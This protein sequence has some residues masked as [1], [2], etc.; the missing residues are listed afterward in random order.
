MR[1]ENEHHVVGGAAAGAGQHGF[2]GP[3]GQVGAAVVGLG[4]IGGTVHGQY[5]TA[6]K[7]M[8]TVAHRV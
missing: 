3:G 8:T 5:M 2:H 7:I 1:L 6:A 4:G